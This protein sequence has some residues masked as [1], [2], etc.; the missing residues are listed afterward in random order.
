MENVPPI[1]GTSYATVYDVVKEKVGEWT[2]ERS[3][4]VTGVPVD[5]I[6]ELARVYAQDGPVYTY[7]QYGCNHYNN[8]TYNYGPMYSLIL[9]PE[10]YASRVPVR[11]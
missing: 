9:Q 11:V 10:T 7:S 2:V 3:S 6:K 5:D 1:E 4:E 8:S